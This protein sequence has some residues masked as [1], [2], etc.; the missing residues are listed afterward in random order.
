LGAGIDYVA[1]G[2]HILDV[3]R[4][5][6]LTKNLV[7]DGFTADYLIPGNATQPAAC[8]VDGN[9]SNHEVTGPLKGA[10]VD[11]EVATLFMSR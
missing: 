2:N 4:C 5:D 10:P 8:V 3:A 6:A 9:F 11:D 1:I 7:E